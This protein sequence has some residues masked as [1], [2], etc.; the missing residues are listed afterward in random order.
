M[1]LTMIEIWE[2]KI[3]IWDKVEI[4]SSNKNSQNT[5]YSMAESSETIAYE[6]AVKIREN[7]RKQ[8]T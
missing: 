5:L 1:N 3:E 6:I 4:I 2:D 7:I 8:I